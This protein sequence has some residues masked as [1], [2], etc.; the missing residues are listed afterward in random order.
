VCSDSRSEEGGGTGGCG[1][2]RRSDSR[3]EEEGGRRDGTPTFL[4]LGV[5]VGGVPG[6]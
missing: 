1:R 4:G 2:Q 5:G 6:A 3:S